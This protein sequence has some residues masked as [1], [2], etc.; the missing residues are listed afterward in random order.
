VST[1]L[2]L[3]VCVYLL[4]LAAFFFYATR[5]VLR[6]PE[7]VPIGPAALRPGIDSA[8]VRAVSAP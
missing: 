3:F 5:L 6:G 7:A 2:L 4:L 1:S 8:P